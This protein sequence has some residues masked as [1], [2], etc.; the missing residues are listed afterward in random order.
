MQKSAILAV[1]CATALGG[2]GAA[3]S[4]VFTPNASASEA[5]KQISIDA[6][7]EVELQ[8]GESAVFRRGDTVKIEQV[9]EG[10]PSRSRSA[11]SAN[12]HTAP[13]CIVAKSE[14]GFIQ[15][16]NNC[17]GTEPQRIKVTLAFAPDTE[18]KSSAPGTRS[19]VG[20]AGTA[21]ISGVYLC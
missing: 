15:V 21:R 11:R 14:K 19:N 18:C 4:D 13:N 6:L 16:Y 12:L 2:F 9:I 20:F 17:G 5:V 3:T 7:M 10:S 8:P 1:A